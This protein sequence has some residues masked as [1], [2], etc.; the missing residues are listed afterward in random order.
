MPG[1]GS[2]SPAWKISFPK[3]FQSSFG[4][5]QKYGKTP[6]SS[7]LIGFSI[8]NHPFW[9]TII[10]GNTHLD[11]IQV[12]SFFSLSGEQNKI[13][14][15]NTT[16]WYWGSDKGHQGW[17]IFLLNEELKNPRILKITG[18]KI[19]VWFLGIFL[20]HFSFPAIEPHP[21]RTASHVPCFPDFNHWD[22]VFYP[23]KETTYH[24]DDTFLEPHGH[25]FA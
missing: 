13:N 1:A 18:F 17:C 23:E 7:I 5:F 3:F 10:F 20:V 22:P 14:I 24:S 8:I 25:S 11:L 6:K 21:N 19:T 2:E 9:G 12:T 4:C 16:L 15:K